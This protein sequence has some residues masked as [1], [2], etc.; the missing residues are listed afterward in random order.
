VDAA[1]GAE[2][3]RAPLGDAIVASAVVVD[4][5]VY[6]GSERTGPDG[7]IAEGVLHALDAV[8][9]RERWQLPVGAA[10]LS[11]AAWVD[12]VLYVGSAAGIAPDGTGGTGALHAVDAA[13]G[14]ERWRFDVGPVFSSPAVVG[15]AAY[16]AGID[17][18]LHAIGG[19]GA[20]APPAPL[21]RP[22]RL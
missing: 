20:G 18:V 5:N 8:T 11:S 10:I 3:W 15:G 19:S 17:G 4:D 1:T 13:T 9:G 22:P 12:G 2:R 7:I 14:V 21:P 16:V 6:V